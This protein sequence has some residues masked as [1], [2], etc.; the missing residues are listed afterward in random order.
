V[1]ARSLS[2]INRD[3]NEQ[4][5]RDQDNGGGGNE[6]GRE[7]KVRCMHFHHRTAKFGTAKFAGHVAPLEIRGQTHKSTFGSARLAGLRDIA[8]PGSAQFTLCPG[9]FLGP[10][11]DLLCTAGT[12][13]L[14]G[15]F[16]QVRFLTCRDR[17]V[18]PSEAVAFHR[19][20]AAH[21]IEIARHISDPATKISLLVMAQ[22]W[23]ALADHTEKYGEITLVYEAPSPRT[24]PQQA[25]QQ[26]QQPRPLSQE[27]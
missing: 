2:R 13:L 18:S 16:R 3:L 27:D 14:V 21:C 6:N 10:S 12:K 7:H 19:L 5:G 9:L 15:R 17:P 22:A 24:E 8:G 1:L 26:Q 25:A 20:N 11:V 23:L 4:Q